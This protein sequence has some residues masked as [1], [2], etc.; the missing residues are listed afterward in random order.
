[1]KKII[2][3]TI[4]LLSI[5]LSSCTIDWQ[6]KNVIQIKE[7][8]DRN[9]ELEKENG[10]LKEDKANKN[11][12]KVEFDDCMIR[13]HEQFVRAG[14]KICLDMEYTLAQIENLECRMS[15]G[16]LDRITKTQT[17]WQEMCI[18]VYDSKK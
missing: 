13:A 9:T 8:E 3:P 7:L 10:E 4:L 16:D 12:A 2:T 18:K 5:L 1:M 14:N 6:D 17:E 15:P 11:D